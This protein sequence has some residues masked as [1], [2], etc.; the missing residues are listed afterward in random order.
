MDRPEIAFE[1]IRSD[2]PKSKMPTNT[3]RMRRRSISTQLRTGNRHSGKYGRIRWVLVG[4]DRRGCRPQV[5]FV[6]DIS[7]IVPN[8]RRMRFTVRPD[9]HSGRTMDPCPDHVVCG[10]FGQIG[11]PVLRERQGGRQPR[12]RTSRVEI[13]RQGERAEVGKAAGDGNQSGR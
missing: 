7:L 10:E 5:P 12:D 3:I 11:R 13:G 8:F 2:V 6:E 1:S 4:E 9:I